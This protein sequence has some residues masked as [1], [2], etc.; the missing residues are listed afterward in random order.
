MR[1]EEL[2]EFGASVAGVTAQRWG[3]AAGAAGADLADLWAEGAAQGWFSL[4][5]EDA[6]DAAV[7]AI[8]E[9]G[10]VACPLPVMDGFVAARVLR[11]EEKLAGQIASGELR[12]LVAADGGTGYLD[13]GTAATHVLTLPAGGGTAELRS[14]EGCRAL[15]GLAMPPW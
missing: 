5:D 8:R 12:V 7:A 10:R 2:A 14:I 1:T 9:L 15:P 6:L 13:G 3:R 4:G 11:G